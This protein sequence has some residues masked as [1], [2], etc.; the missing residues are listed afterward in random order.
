[1]TFVLGCV[2]FGVSFAL[3]ARVFSGTFFDEKKRREERDLRN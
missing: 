1:M 3:L 2:I